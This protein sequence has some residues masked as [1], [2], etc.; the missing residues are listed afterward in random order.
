[1]SGT[2]NR[3]VEIDGNICMLTNDQSNAY[4]KLLEWYE[5]GTKQ[6]VINGNAGC[7]KS[8]LIRLL[9]DSL[10]CQI[11]YTSLTGKACNVLTRK[12]LN[13]QT[14]HSLIYDVIK[15]Y[16]P[17]TRKYNYTFNLKSELPY[18]IVVVDEYSMLGSDLY[19]DL[20]S[21]DEVRLI[22][23]GDPAQL[24]PVKSKSLQFTPDAVLSEVV[25]TA[26]NNPI[27]MFATNV[28]N[29]VYSL[30]D[31][32]N[33]DVVSIIDDIDV[34]EDL[35]TNGKPQIICGYNKTRES[36]NKQIRSILH[37]N[38]IYPMVGETLICTNNNRRLVSNHN[39]PL[40]NGCQFHVIKRSDHDITD[41]RLPYIRYNL[42][43]DG[44][45]NY[46]DVKIY[47]GCF[48]DRYW[49]QDP[50]TDEWKLINYV[51]QSSGRKS[52]ID[53]G[54]FDYGYAITAH[55]SQGSEYPYVIAYYEPVGSNYVDNW[56]YTVITRSKN[57]LIIIR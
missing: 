19:R 10:H 45:E 55:K 5:S 51:T 6:F 18:D 24:P 29:H 37:Y 35:L 50:K 40:L 15:E 7:G 44:T 11:A 34:T 8:T 13:A 46:F 25:R 21:F 39:T 20:M 42:Q 38:E 48:N 54:I 49:E 4:N 22:L 33:N 17:A 56:L 12:G 30:D 52:I 31:Y 26:L 53:G 1:M 23:V 2:S 9:A 41:N 57:K 16:D 43:E 14:V 32:V 36:I 28:R 27:T 47:K 3:F